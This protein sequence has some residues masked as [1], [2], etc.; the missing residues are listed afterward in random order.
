M[1]S[2]RREQQ[3][4]E[5]WAPVSDLMAVVMLVFMLITLILLTHFD[6]ERRSNAEQCSEIRGMLDAE[7][8]DNFREWGAELDE[9][10]TIRFTNQTVLFDANQA[11]PRDWF[12]DKIEKFFPRYMEIVDNVS[13]QYGENEVVAVRIEGHTSSEYEGSKSVEEAYM[14]NMQ[15]SQDRAR[16]ILLVALNLPESGRYSDIVRQRGRADGLSSS[17]LI[18]AEDGKENRTS[19]RRVEFKLLAQSCQKAGVYDK[20]K[21]LS[22]TCP[23]EGFH[24]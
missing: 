16:A 7:F 15:L 12:E 10:L 17:K 18:C 23:T 11:I 3:D 6:L 1:L 4:D 14:K 13:I 24:D 21:P 22:Y 20:V 19:S 8:G 2:H 9:D 5:Q